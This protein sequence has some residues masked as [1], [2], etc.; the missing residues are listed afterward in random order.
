MSNLFN[1]NAHVPG[2][3]DS[4]DDPSKD[5]PMKESFT[6][7][8]GIARQFEI[9]MREVSVGYL[10]DA[11]EVGKSIGYRFSAFDAASPYL[12]LGNLR[13]KMR[14]ALAT[15]HIEAPDGNPSALH[16]TLR[17]Y[18]TGDS[19]VE[20]PI[21]VVDGQALQLSDIARIASTHEGFQFRLEFFDS[22]DTV[23]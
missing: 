12:A 5:F 23:P 4:P 18:I 11:T 9:T 15:R 6:D 21:F 20:G 13:V 2:E 8:S 1:D 22:T 10:L 14:R 16:D 19:D 3:G 17:G 7:F